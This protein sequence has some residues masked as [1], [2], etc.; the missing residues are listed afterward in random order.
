M[1]PEVAELVEAL[2]RDMRPNPLT[3]RPI[4]IRTIKAA[5]AAGYGD[6]AARQLRITVH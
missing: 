2:M 5:V 4:D 1:H 3:G 6:Q